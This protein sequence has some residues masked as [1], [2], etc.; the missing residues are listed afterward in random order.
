MRRNSAVSG[1]DL[2][3]L[4]RQSS[5]HY[6]VAALSLKS[7]AAL[8]LLSAAAR[9]LLSLSP[10]I[11]ASISLVSRHTLGTLAR[12]FFHFQ[13][14]QLSFEVFLRACMF[15]ATAD[16]SQRDRGCASCYRKT[17][18]LRSEM[19]TRQATEGRVEDA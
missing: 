19:R 13:A 8:S 17:G 4:R 10:A 11:A 5:T 1:T 9:S 6:F 12:I 14:A 2:S 7:S 3:P 15:D 16:T 18:E